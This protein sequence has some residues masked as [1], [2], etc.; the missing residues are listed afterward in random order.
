MI[1]GP[2]QPHR[3][4]PGL[5]Q[6][7]DLG[8]DNKTTARWSEGIGQPTQCTSLLGISQYRGTLGPWMDP[9]KIP[10]NRTAQSRVCV[11]RQGP[12]WPL[13]LQSSRSLD[14]SVGPSSL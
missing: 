11:S 2:T 14:G 3:R 5:N 1:Y 7:V 6:N 10:E 9:E 4:D 12:L 8:I 13:E